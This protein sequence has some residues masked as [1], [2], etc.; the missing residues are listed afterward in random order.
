RDV[1]LTPEL[2]RG[3]THHFMSAT[4][5]IAIFGLK[6]VQRWIRNRVREAVTNCGY[7]LRNPIDGL[8]GLLEV[9]RFSGYA[10]PLRH[11]L[12]KRLHPVQPPAKITELGR[13]PAFPRKHFFPRIQSRIHLSNRTDELRGGPGWPIQ[14]LEE[15]VVE[16]LPE[17]LLVCSFRYAVVDPPL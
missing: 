12:P 5:Q 9:T 16:E 1:Q 14:L 15:K 6:Q 7:V 8:N 10:S 4:D 3:F 13:E 17:S 2:L 11:G